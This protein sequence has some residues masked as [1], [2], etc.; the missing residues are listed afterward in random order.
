MGY[1]L[2]FIN[3]LHLLY[4]YK[5]VCRSTLF[6]H[7]Y[8]FLSTCY[9][10]QMETHAG[11]LLDTIIYKCKDVMNNALEGRVQALKADSTT[12]TTGHDRQHDRHEN[13]IRRGT[14]ANSA[15]CV[16]STLTRSVRRFL[17]KG[18]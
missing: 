2:S 11:S 18:I 8:I 7:V 12:G 4:Y 10:G 9:L 1:S 13:G 6:F 3:Y 5:V 17:S 15:K 16:L 14:L